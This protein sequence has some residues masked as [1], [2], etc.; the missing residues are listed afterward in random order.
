MHVRMNA[1]AITAV[2]VAILTVLCACVSCSRT[3]SDDTQRYPETQSVLVGRVLGALGA[4]RAELNAWR[5]LQAGDTVA[6][7][8]PLRVSAEGQAELV[9]GSARLHLGP[10]AVVAAQ[11]GGHTV[12]LQRGSLCAETPAGTGGVIVNTAFG[13][14]QLHEGEVAIQCG[15][16]RTTA[17]LLRGA[18]SVWPAGAAPQPL[19]LNTLIE[20]SN[21]QVRSAQASETPPVPPR[22]TDE[23]AQGIGRLVVRDSAGREADALEVR[24]LRVRAHIAGAVALTEVEE[25]FYNPTDRRA[26]GTFYF[27]VPAGASLSRFAMFVDGRLVEGELVDRE[28]ARTVYEEIVRK[29]QDPALMEWQEGNVF[30]TRIFPIPPHGPKR[31]LI[32]YTQSLPALDGE[33][34]YVYPLACKT[35]Q[36]G[37]IGKFELEVEVAGAGPFAPRA[38]AY[39]E[40]QVE[41]GKDLTHIRLA[42][43]DFHP[44]RDFA[45]RFA[46]VRSQPLELLTDR[47]AGED[48][49][50]LLSYLPEPRARQATADGRTPAFPQ[51]AAR[52]VVLLFDTSLSRRADDYKA[53]LKAAHALLHELGP[54]DRFAAIGFDVAARAQQRGF[55]SGLAAAEKTLQDLQQVLPLGATNIEAAFEALAKFLD[56]HK[57]RGQAEVICLSDGIATLG[58][59][60]S[61]KLAGKIVPLLAKHKARV[62][63]VAMGAQHD[64]LLLRELARRTGGL[65]RSIIPG[66]DV[67]REVFRLSLALESELL[68]APTLRFSGVETH[69]IYPSQPDTLVAGEELIMLGRYKGAGRLSVAAGQDGGAAAVATFDLPETDSRNVYVPRLWARERL[70]ELLLAPQTE[71]LARQITDL[72]QEFTLITP[73][74]SFLVLESEADY[75]K[76][77]IAR[78][79]RRRYWE[80]MGKL[81]TAPPAE[82]L[83]PQPVQ[84]APQPPA[85]PEQIVKAKDPEPTPAPAPFTLADLDLSLLGQKFGE[86]REVATALSALSLEVYYRYLQLDVGG[87]GGA[88]A[89][90]NVDAARNTVVVAAVSDAEAPIQGRDI[91]AVAERVAPPAPTDLTPENLEA[92]RAE[93]EDDRHA[94]Q[95]GQE[96]LANFSFAGVGGGF[97]VAAESGEGHG[98]FG[99]RSG[100]GRRLMVA[101]HGGSRATESGCDMSL[102]W[103]ACHQFGD[104]HWGA[105]GFQETSLALLAFLGAGHTEKVG[106][107]KVHVGKAVQWLKARQNAAGQIGQDVF[108]QALTAL[109]LSEAAGMANVPETKEAAQRAIDRLVVLQTRNPAGDRLGW[110]QR[111]GDCHP[112]VTAWAVMALR[113][114]KIAGLRVEPAAWDGAILYCDQITG[115]NGAVGAAGKPQGN[116]VHLLHTAAGA[117]ARQF[118]GWKREDRVVAGPAD[119][120]LALA[121]G[122]HNMTPDGR[123]VRYFGALLMFQQGGEYWRRWNEWLKNE[124]I[125]SQCKSGD[126]A[127]S[128]EPTGIYVLG[129]KPAQDPQAA[130]KE[131]TGAVARFSAA[132]QDQGAYEAFAVA[133]AQ[134][135]DAVCLRGLIEQTPDAPAVARAV[136]R[137]RLGM[138][139]L[140][141]KDNDGALR[142]FREA[143]DAT[144]WPENFLKY[145]LGAAQRTGKAREALDLLLADAA[146]GKTSE[147][148]RLMTATLLFDAKANIEDPVAY[149]SQKLGSGPAEHMALK[150]V[151]AQA[152][153]A[154][155]RHDAELAFFQQVYT[156]SQRDEQYAAP[157]VEAMQSCGRAAEAL[158]MLIA[159]GAEGRSSRWRVRTIA[160]LL[161]AS[162]FNDAEIV[163]RVADGLSV[164]VDI[165]LAVC[166]QTATQAEQQQRLEL[167]AALM[168]KA[169]ADSGRRERHG[170][171]YVRLLRQS[172]KARPALELLTRE[173]R[174]NNRL[175][176]WRMRALAEILLA[177]QAY[178]AAPDRY[179]DEAFAQRPRARVALK[180]E[181]AGAADAAHNP[182]LAARLYEDIYLAGG[183]PM[184]VVQPYVSA[185]V[186]DGQTAKA[187]RE[188]EQVIQA[189][190]HTAWAFQTLAQCY[191]RAERGAVEVLRAASSEVEIFP[192][193]VQPH[194]NLAQ[195]YEEARQPDEALAQHWEAIRLKPEG[196]YFYKQV[197]ERAI[198]LGRN[199]VARQALDEMSRR[200][201][202]Q[203]DIWGP[204]EAELLQLLAKQENEAGRRDAELAKRIRQYLVKDLVVV[205]SWDTNG[206]DIDLH[207][208]EPAGEECFYSHKTTASGGALDHDNTTGLGP[209]TYALRRAKPGKYKI[210]VEYFAGAPVTVATVRIYRNRNGDNETLATKTVELTKAKERVTVDIVDVPEA[211]A[212]K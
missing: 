171:H 117:L 47:R 6:S 80:E 158:A 23:P 98:S 61:E 166:L 55:V 122:S 165:R 139:L 10:G 104:G 125:Q 197:V 209:E 170:E 26:E 163:A 120:L 131:L 17:R 110:G 20:T 206:T 89:M 73:Y 40:A 124:L 49:F 52:D 71:E 198:A 19:E 35:T 203:A 150:V 123:Y 74:T 184:A 46:A 207:V 76:Y 126:N 160:N 188:L 145:Y 65:F 14:V 141:Q 85:P 113:S 200:F 64:R 181:L 187:M 196:P 53:Q 136:L 94:A 194:I 22:A 50:F 109:A 190:Y 202:N 107:Y 212:R 90:P 18:G 155:G 84:P 44:E 208:T 114:A 132:S 199:A 91:E 204:G 106:E 69:S 191:R 96:F 21:G 59:T 60:A 156:G 168:E 15:E 195:Y 137:V 115:E 62:H 102:H 118:M 27:P 210:D 87:G 169:Y 154:K 88:A 182:K 66:D 138:V 72:S 5:E 7:A 93:T 77:G 148:R 108:D 129:R 2:T 179:A 101:R 67:E 178:K 33:R 183:K 112:F 135:T 100:G 161:L 116:E 133:L 162:K 28:R 111:Q 95:G 92:N 63:A 38:P 3:D 51:R 157:Y 167:G 144:G 12:A 86:G 37:R 176:Q 180:Y 45:L 43:K 130:A 105:A 173:A 75:Q 127:G 159:E 68:P 9:A 24:E 186:A 189:G 193:D 58:E 146:G 13:G 147:W 82:E 56:E 177:D 153:K 83:Q 143:C 54:E 1:R 185:L 164:H 31:I 201:P 81:R 121:T 42:R 48:G 8:V 79:K 41:N 174:D 149:V 119:L 29:M 97:E 151:L 152:A 172:G 16:T 175:S 11:N 30:K 205:L 78:H 32:S 211:P 39:P 4:W 99:Y 70:D 57:T 140:Q 192:R 25:T 34:R 142:Q 134:T 103:L 128:W 36:A